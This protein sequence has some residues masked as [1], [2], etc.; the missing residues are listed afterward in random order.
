MTLRSPIRPVA[1]PSSFSRSLESEALEALD[2]RTTYFVAANRQWP[3]LSQ[4]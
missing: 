2:H 3:Q 1:M 4:T